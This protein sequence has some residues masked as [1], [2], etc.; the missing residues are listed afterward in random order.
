MAREPIEICLV[1]FVFESAR[2][3]QGEH[4]L[5][6]YGVVGDEAPEHTSVFE[7]HVGIPTDPLRVDAR[8]TR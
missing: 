7:R 1:D 3:V 5:K 4:A 8:H 6:E 2:L